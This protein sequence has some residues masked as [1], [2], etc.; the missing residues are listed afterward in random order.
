MYPQKCVSRASRE[1]KIE[2]GNHRVYHPNGPKED[3]DQLLCLHAPMRSR[4]ALEERVRA[5]ERADEA[6]RRKGQGRNRRRWAE[7][8][9]TGVEEEWAANSYRGYHLDVYGE[10]HPVIFDPLLRD[11]V[12]PFVKKPPWKRLLGGR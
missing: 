1:L 2:I 5:S 10:R 3:T 12:A 7:M 9:K 8:G 6:G 4:A 11:A